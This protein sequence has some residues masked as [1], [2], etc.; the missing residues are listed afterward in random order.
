MN[1]S[2]PTTLALLPP[3]SLL[4]LGLAGQGKTRAAEADWADGKNRFS[5]SGS[6]LFNVH[7]NFRNVGQIGGSAAPGPVAGGV[8]HVYDNGFV[9]VDAT[10]NQGGLTWNW[11]Y[12][13][14]AGISGDSLL[15]SSFAGTS[16][17]DSGNLDK[18]PQPGFELAYGRELLDFGRLKL[19]LE[20][21]GGYTSAGFHD[22]RSF[23]SDYTSI[24]DA[25]SLGGIIPPLPPYSGNAP[26]PGPLISDTPVRSSS[27]TKGGAS[28]TGQHVLDV[29]LYNFRFGPWLEYAPCRRCSLEIGGGVAW[30]VL[31]SRYHFSETVSVPGRSG[32]NQ[33]G[34]HD[35]TDVKLGP[36]VGG[37]ISVSLTDTISIFGAA[38]YEKLG[39]SS[40]PAA[41]S[42][43]ELDLRDS[44]FA[45][46]GLSFDF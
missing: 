26:G 29:D 16:G 27:I 43:A 30:A 2:R 37:A 10:G 24:T 41:N 32:V 6:M 38:Q 20:L 13:P 44:I 28:I 1:S 35:L 18:S 22:S 12:S 7:A 14:Q 9:G 5:V 8:P 40:N 17:T 23:A 36:W 39:H 4:L 11:G 31:Q 46:F 42:T 45:R 15:L 21:G 19:G 25:Y 33:S 3:A 34:S